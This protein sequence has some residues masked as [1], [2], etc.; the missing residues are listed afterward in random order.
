MGFGKKIIA[1]IEANREARRR[2]VRSPM[3]DF[4][5]A[6]GNSLLYD[7]PITSSDVIIDAGGYTGE[8]TS[9]ALVRY[10]C[11]SEILEPVPEFARVCNELFRRNSLVRVHISAL[12]AVS[13]EMNLHLDGNA[14][15]AFVESDRKAPVVAPVSGVCEFI[16]SIGYPR[17]GCLKLN[18]EGAEYEVLERLLAS[19]YI[20]RIDCLLIQFHRQPDN[21]STRYQAIRTTLQET[22]HMEWGFEMVWE[23]WVCSAY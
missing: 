3:G 7:L 16:D 17:I 13:G 5:R 11:R 4:Y 23:K 9:G 6:G 10:G 15:S 1:F 20:R 22:H 19:G 18:V 14:S 12:G 21:W 2:R 8:W